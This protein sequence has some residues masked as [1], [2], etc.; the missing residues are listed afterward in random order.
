MYISEIIKKVDLKS[1]MKWMILLLLFLVFVVIYLFVFLCLLNTY[2]DITILFSGILGGSLSLFLLY[3]RGGKIIKKD[4]SIITIWIVLIT[5]IFTIIPIFII[6]RKYFTLI[7][8]NYLSKIIIYE[9]SFFI[10]LFFIIIFVIFLQNKDL[11]INYKNKIKASLIILLV[12]FFWPFYLNIFYMPYHVNGFYFYDGTDDIQKTAFSL[13]NNLPSDEEKL[14]ALLN[15]QLN[16][17]TNVYGQNLIF[18]KP[19]LV[20]NRASNNYNLSMYYKHGVCGDF[21]LLLSELATTSGIENRRIYS[22]GENHEWIE[23]KI[24]E[25]NHSWVNADAA[26]FWPNHEYVYNDSN[27]YGNQSRVY[28]EDMS[29]KQI[30]ITEKYSTVGNLSIFIKSDNQDVTSFDIKIISSQGNSIFPKIPRHPDSNGYFNYTLGTKNYTVIAEKYYFLGLIGYRDLNNSVIVTEN[31]TT[32]IV[33]EPK[34]Q[35]LNILKN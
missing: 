9:I 4:M 20:I 16:N 22:P 21:S 6:V 26:W 1:Q 34:K 19:Y 11:L 23:V 33:I 5:G 32:M 17:F 30:D 2:N 10:P 3:F 15:W 25:N 24:S 28:Y 12:I 18:M 35:Y 13:T 14:I 27:A 31:K 8:Y 29:N 7:F